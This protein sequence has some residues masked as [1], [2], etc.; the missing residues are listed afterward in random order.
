MTWESDPYAEGFYLRMGAT[1][2]GARA[3]AY[4]ETAADRI[5]DFVDAGLP[6]TAVPA[7]DSP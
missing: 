1:R 3:R 7:G 6:S 4:K 2:T 5:A